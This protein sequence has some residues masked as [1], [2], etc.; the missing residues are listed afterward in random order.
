MTSRRLSD[1][2]RD[3]VIADIENGMPRAQIMF[4]HNVS[5]S[6][7][8]GIVGRRKLKLAAPIKAPPKPR[9]PRYTPVPPKIPVPPRQ[10]VDATDIPPH[11]EDAPKSLQISLLDIVDGQ[12]RYTLDEHHYKFCGHPTGDITRHWCPYHHKRVYTTTA[13]VL[14]PAVRVQSART[15]LMR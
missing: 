15:G 13:K 5:N 8:S 14:K 7:V 4:K 12:C 6:Q 2:E 10:D 9:P 11:T 3:A 1:A